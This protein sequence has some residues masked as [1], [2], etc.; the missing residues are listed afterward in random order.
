M[1]TNLPLKNRHIEISG[2]KMP[3]PWD[4][5][6]LLPQAAIVILVY[7]LAYWGLSTRGVGLVP[8]Y[9]PEEKVEFLACVHFSVVTL[10]SLGYGDFRPTSWISM[11][12]SW[13]EVV[14]GLLFFG[15]LVSRL[16]GW[17]SERLLH[18]V[19]KSQINNE[20]QEFRHE[21]QRIAREYSVLIDASLGGT[22]TID[23]GQ[24][25]YDISDFQGNILSEAKYLLSGFTRYMRHEAEK[26][27]FFRYV[28][29]RALTRLSSEIVYCLRQIRRHQ[30][31]LANG[32][33]SKKERR[34]VKVALIAISDYAIALSDSLAHERGEG[35]S[36][37]SRE[38][39]R[40]AAEIRSD[41]DVDR[42]DS[43]GE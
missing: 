36:Y 31:L 30:Q 33:L 32:R 13:T 12:L 5:L 20:L 22:L 4:V 19:A 41:L 21:V 6:Y 9:D 8:T 25:L 3:Y 42:K 37:S 1:S 26:F 17:R 10:T 11:F 28:P 27:D 23:E 29:Q 16:S 18:R 2:S 38:L 34:E 24:R 43:E 39:M 7:A 35:F 15:L 40:V 14:L